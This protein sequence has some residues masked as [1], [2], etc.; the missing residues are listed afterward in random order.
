[1]A[2]TIAVQ[3]WQVGPATSEAVM[4]E[5]RVLVDRPLEKGGENRGPLGGELFLSAFAG[6]FMSNLLAAIRAREAPVANVRARSPAHWLKRR[7]ASRRLR[8]RFRRSVRTG[9][10]WK[11]W[12]ASPSEG[13]S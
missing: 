9:S 7:A 13:A 11:S 1:M 5:H 4:R 10:C 3:V 6:C 12:S 2:N 8:L